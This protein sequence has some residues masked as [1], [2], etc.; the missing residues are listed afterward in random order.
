VQVSHPWSFTD[1]FKLSNSTICMPAVASLA[2]KQGNNCFP[3]CKPPVQTFSSWIVTPT[4]IALHASRI[5][6]EHMQ[7]QLLSI[8]KMQAASMLSICM[9]MLLRLLH[10]KSP[11][12][13]PHLP[14]RCSTTLF[15]LVLCLTTLFALN[16]T[17]C[18]CFASSLNY[19]SSCSDVGFCSGC[20]RAANSSIIAA[21]LVQFLTLCS[22]SA[23]A[24]SITS[25]RIVS[26]SLFM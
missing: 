1:D 3:T 26:K 19:A 17:S 25:R 10:R 24:C 12:H 2:T 23:S 14:N 11:G 5:S 21:H 7:C 15:A 20:S 6:N 16:V 13:S 18:C 9:H 4:I 8:W 22:A